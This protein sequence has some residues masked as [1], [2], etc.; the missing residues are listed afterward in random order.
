MFFKYIWLILQLFA[1][2]PP[3]QSGNTV[4]VVG[5]ADHT[6]WQASAPL[7][8]PLQL[9]QFHEKNLRTLRERH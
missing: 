8:E 5:E 4:I 2:F 3:F 7:L 6:I 9:R 1:H